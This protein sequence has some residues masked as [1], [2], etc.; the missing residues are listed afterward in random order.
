MIISGFT[1]HQYKEAGRERK[2]IGAATYFLYHV[3][4][5]N[6]KAYKMKTTY[7]Y[8]LFECE[9]IQYLGGEYHYHIEYK[10]KMLFDSR[11][12]KKVFNTFAE[13]HEMVLK[14]IISYAN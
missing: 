13:C 1:F 2:D 10:D 7:K 4:L 5:E 3:G 12:G 14:Q 11:L 8:R 6:Q 9:I